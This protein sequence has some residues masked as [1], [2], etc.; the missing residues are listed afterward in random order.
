MSGFIARLLL[1]GDNMTI[2]SMEQFI[3]VFGR[4]PVSVYLENPGFFV[5]GDLSYPEEFIDHVLVLAE[6][7]CTVFRGECH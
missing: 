5:S 6:T 3:D 7:F 2:S 1:G 4:H